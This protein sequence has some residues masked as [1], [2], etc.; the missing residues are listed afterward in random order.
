MYQRFIIFLLCFLVGCGKVAEDISSQSNKSIFK[1]A[2]L[3]FDFS[4]NE[5]NDWSA[6]I[7]TDNVSTV[8]S[9]YEGLALDQ[10]FEK[11]G[12]VQADIGIQR[13]ASK[14]VP[15]VS[16]FD[17]KKNVV[18][19]SRY[20]QGFIS[21]QKVSTANYRSQTEFRKVRP[22]FDYYSFSHFMTKDTYLLFVSEDVPSTSVSITPHQH[23]ISAVYLNHL[24]KESYNR[25]TVIPL[26]VFYEIISTA[27]IA[28]TLNHTPKNSI[29]TFQPSRPIFSIKSS[30][31]DALLTT[32]TLSYH[33]EEYDVFDY[34]DSTDLT[35]FP[36]SMKV[37]LKK[38]VGRYFKSKIKKDDALATENVTEKI[39]D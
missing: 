16:N 24:K 34:I 8:Y 23:V 31:F 2:L 37:H 20:Q 4:T 35:I 3:S 28:P 27:S 21:I 38:S 13:I 22:K 6:L 19:S 33:S 25:D 17:L 30:L 9:Y 11:I 32:V 18:T 10:G 26:T 5:V 36:E 29:K 15:V 7:S 1:T 39:N 12:W 14:N